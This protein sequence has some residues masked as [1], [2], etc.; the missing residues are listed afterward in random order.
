[1]T[2]SAA[3]KRVWWAGS[4]WVK[5][6]KPESK[7]VCQ[8]SGGKLKQKKKTEQQN[9][10]EYKPGQPNEVTTCWWLAGAE[11]RTAWWR[12]RRTRDPFLSAWHFAVNANAARTCYTCRCTWH[13][14]MKKRPHP[15]SH[16]LDISAS[17]RS[18]SRAT[19]LNL[20]NQQHHANCNLAR[21]WVK[22]AI[23]THRL[24]NYLAPVKS[25]RGR[26]ELV[27]SPQF[28]GAS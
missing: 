27:D 8:M 13:L 7:I 9:R 23:S 3:S 20:T 17:P 21:I 18:K 4:N 28:S 14:V 11:E 1:M 15:E 5:W 19:T 16:L 12:N 2:I 26:E 6:P 24:S 25:R 22:I 10:N